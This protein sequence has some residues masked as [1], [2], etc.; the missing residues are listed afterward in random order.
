MNNYLKSIKYLMRILVIAVMI[1]GKCF[2]VSGEE[3]EL[4]ENFS[5][6]FKT[7]EDIG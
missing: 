7:S 6:V 4:K 3:Y 2:T 1:F 5:M